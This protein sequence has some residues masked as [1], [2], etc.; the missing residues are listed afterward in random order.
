[1]CSC[2]PYNRTRVTFY[3]DK[4]TCI[5]RLCEPYN[6]TSTTFCTDKKAKKII[7]FTIAAK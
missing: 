7:D 2:A 5:A 4:N 6:R 3:T 1:M